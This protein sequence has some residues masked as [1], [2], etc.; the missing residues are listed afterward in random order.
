MWFSDCCGKSWFCERV[1]EG[2]AAGLSGE[3]GESDTW[4][5]LHSKHH[6]YGNYCHCCVF[7]VL[8]D[9]EICDGSHGDHRGCYGDDH[10]DDPC[11]YEICH[12]GVS[13]HGDAL[14][15]D[16]VHE[17]WETHHYVGDL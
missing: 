12:Y 10:C 4:D 16:D 11:G 17:T 9:D 3:E 8:H 7:A 5:A 15:G 13:L 1:S 2:G 6:H 14:H